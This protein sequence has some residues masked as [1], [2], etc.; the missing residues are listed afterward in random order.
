MDKI[1]HVCQAERSRMDRKRAYPGGIRTLE[2]RLLLQRYHQERPLSRDRKEVEWE[3]STILGKQGLR[4][5]RRARM[6]SIS[7]RNMLKG[8][9]NSNN[10]HVVVGRTKRNQQQKVLG[11]VV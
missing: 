4:R 8:P 10:P 6:K 2:Q 5:S 11:W 3:V 7:D 9:G 1:I